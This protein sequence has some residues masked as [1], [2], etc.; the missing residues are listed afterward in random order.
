M[1]S[2]GLQSLVLSNRRGLATFSVHLSRAGYLPPV[3]GPLQRPSFLH[4]SGALKGIRLALPGA[5]GQRKDNGQRMMWDQR[6]RGIEVGMM[7]I[8]L[9]HS[10]TR[11]SSL[12]SFPFH[13]TREMWSELTATNDSNSRRRIMIGRERCP[14]LLALRLSI[15]LNTESMSGARKKLN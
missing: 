7:F 8:S 12:P 3:G 5:N 13:Q 14:H 10:L 11:S 4:S 2:I 9:T 1:L 15:V 6:W